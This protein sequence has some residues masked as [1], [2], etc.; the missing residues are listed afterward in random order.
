MKDLPKLPT[1]R[2]EWD[3][4]LRPSGRKAPNLPLSQHLILLSTHDQTYPL[5]FE[6]YPLRFNETSLCDSVQSYH[7]LESSVLATSLSTLHS[8][9]QEVLQGALSHSTRSPE[10]CPVSSQEI[11][12]N[13]MSHSTRHST[14]SPTWCPVS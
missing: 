5:R 2:L 12:H 1:W 8:A 7:I 11:L 14:R 10:W 13:P 3:S 6:T 4:N 9:V